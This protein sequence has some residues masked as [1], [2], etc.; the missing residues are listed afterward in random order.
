MTQREIEQSLQLVPHT[1]YARGHTLSSP[2][3]MFGYLHRRGIVFHDPTT[4]LS[5]RR[6]PRKP[7]LPLCVQDYQDASATAHSPQARLVLALAAVHAARRHN[8]RLLRL[9]AVDLAQRRLTIGTISRH[10]DEL[11][12]QAFLDYLHHRRQR[13]P[14][15][16]NPHVLISTHTALDQRPISTYTIG[17]EF[18]GLRASLERLRQDRQ[19]DEALIHGPDPLHLA[20]VFGISHTTASHYARAAQ[21]LLET[22][23]ETHNTE[24]QA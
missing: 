8:I 19:L 21:Q 4:R 24:Q 9:D 20:V 23:A 6:P 5:I 13:W 17:V 1:G 15:T 22:D 10:L 18:R 14:H 16:A 3:L 7:L 12:H 11:T 2:R